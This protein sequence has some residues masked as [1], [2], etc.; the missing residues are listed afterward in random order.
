MTT[1]KIVMIQAGNVKL[2]GDLSIPEDAFSLVIFVHGSGSSRKS[3]RNRFVAAVLQEAGIATLLFDLLTSEE[4]SE[5]AFTGNL[6]FNIEFLASRLQYATNLMLSDS[7]VGKLPFGYFGAST[8]AAA[9]LASSAGYPGRIT[10]IVSRGGR[11]D[12]AK[13]Y[14]SR[15]D[16]PTLLIVG[17]S[18]TAVIGMNEKA[19][20][21]LMVEKK[22]EIIP[23]ATHLFEEKGAIE[24]V[25]KLATGW[26]VKYLMPG[27]LYPGRV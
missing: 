18:D 13:D 11:P 14:L 6:R 27:R 21:L 23:G 7:I 15:V 20:N 4:E 16:S 8:G 22:I 10:A 26:F 2:E 25:A 1:N 19:Y 9:A 17:G 24:E 5:D 12:L 3:P